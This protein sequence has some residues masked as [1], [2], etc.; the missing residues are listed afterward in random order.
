MNSADH[1]GTGAPTR[2]AERSSASRRALLGRADEGVR[3][4]AK[5]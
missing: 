4:Y 3:P 5:P 1:V 2:P